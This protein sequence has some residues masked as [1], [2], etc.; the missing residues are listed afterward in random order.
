MARKAFGPLIAML[1]LGILLWPQLG[2][3][4]DFRCAGGFSTPTIISISPN[5]V[6]S[7]EFQSGGILIV[8][9]TNFFPSSVVIVNGSNHPTAFVN[10]GELRVTLLP[11]EI[12]PGNLSFV[13]NNP[14]SFSGNFSFLCQNGGES[15]VFAVSI[16]G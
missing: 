4:G 6:S 10:G 5:P 7:F 14:S 13:V 15:S 2:C 11:S 1:L 12:R 9:G 3:I 8:S 16:R